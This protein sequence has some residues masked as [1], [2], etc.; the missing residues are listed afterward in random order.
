MIKLLFFS[1][2]DFSSISFFSVWYLSFVTIQVA[3][4]QAVLINNPCVPTDAD[5]ELALSVPASSDAAFC[6]FSK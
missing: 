4:K 5:E 1:H 3:K 6:I 2:L